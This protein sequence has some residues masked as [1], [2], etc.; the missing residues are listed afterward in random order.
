MARLSP[1]ERALPVAGRRRQPPD[2][3]IRVDQVDRA[4]PVASAA[5]RPPHMPLPCR[6]PQSEGGPTGRPPAATT[7]EGHLP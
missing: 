4:P 3:P 6:A 5:R 7:Q 1:V 2:P